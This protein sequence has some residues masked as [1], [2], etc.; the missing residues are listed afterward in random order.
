V[1]FTLPSLIESITKRLNTN[2]DL[3]RVNSFLESEKYL[4]SAADAFKQ[5]IETISTN[6]RWMNKYSISIQNWLSNVNRRH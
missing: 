2:Y 5:A 1:A 6:I 4:G 3:K